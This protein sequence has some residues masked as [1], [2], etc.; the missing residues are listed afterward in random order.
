MKLGGNRIYYYDIS[1]FSIMLN[2]LFNIPLAKKGIDLLIKQYTP[3]KYI[4]EYEGAFFL[5]ENNTVDLTNSFF[6]DMR[7]SDSIAVKTYKKHYSTNRIDT[8]AKFF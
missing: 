4:S 6:C 7:I 3:S 1:S 2:T 5:I 8:V